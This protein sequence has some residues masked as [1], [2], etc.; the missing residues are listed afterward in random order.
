VP[1][2]ISDTSPLQ[3]LFQTGLLGTLRLLFGKI[4]VPD[5]VAEELTAGRGL[6]VSVPDPRDHDWMFI[7]RAGRIN[8]DL[9]AMGLGGGETEALAIASES[10]AALVLL[11][12]R[13][14]RRYAKKQG[15]DYTGTVGILIL[16]KRAGHIPAVLPV[17]DRLESLRF[18]LDPE[19]RQE[20]LRLAG[21]R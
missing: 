2:V 8:P 6:A 1:P 3:Y 15:M 16:A 13:D 12:D 18:R 21:E 9:Q 10:P 20:V 17:L 11:D 14:A 5:A 4:V 19:M 7:Q